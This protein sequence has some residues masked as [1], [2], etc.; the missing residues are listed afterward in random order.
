MSS[1]STPRLKRSCASGPC[2]SSAL[3]YTPSASARR[4]ASCRS[5][6][7]SIS[8]SSELATASAGGSITFRP[9]V[10]GSPSNA[11]RYC[12]DSA[13]Q[14]LAPSLTTT[15]SPTASMLRPESGMVSGNW[16]FNSFSD[17]LIR[18]AG[19]RAAASAWAVR[20]TIR[21]WNEKRSVLRGPRLGV[22]KPASTSARIV[23]R[24]RRRSFSTS[25][26][27]NWCTLFLGGLPRGGLDGRGRRRGLL[28]RLLLQA[29]AQGFHQVDDLGALLRRLG[30][31]DLLPLDLLL[32]RGLDTRADV[33]G[34]GR[35]V[36]FLRRL[37]L[38]QLLR[39]LELGGLDVHLRNV[40]V[41]DAAHFASVEELLHDEAFD[42][43]GVHRSDHDDVL[44]AARR[45]AAKRAAP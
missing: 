18:F 2:A 36:E 4:P 28:R 24:G 12:P 22:T 39:Q 21:S 9:P 33:V 34:V 26:T 16:R 13:C 29:G 10:T 30:H 45:P 8:S 14:R 6:P 17:R 43:T 44:L 11:S 38:D 3:R 32:H 19:T 42:Q 5:K 37:L 35:G 23:L 15:R 1:S 7:W 25:R 27:P 31:G 41:V 20:S 40:D